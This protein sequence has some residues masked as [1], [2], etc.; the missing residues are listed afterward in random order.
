MNEPLKAG[1]P[2][3][4]IGG[5]G[6]QKSPNLNLTVTVKHRIYGAHGADHA[7]FGAIYRCEG[8]G[9]S[10]LTDAGTYQVTG[11]ADFA[12]SWL[13]K[14]VPPALPSKEQIRDLVLNEDPV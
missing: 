11:W 9:V 13:Q 1:D 6:R 12:G 10:Q 2:C 4:V 3:L 5:Q 7:Q 8:D 14:I